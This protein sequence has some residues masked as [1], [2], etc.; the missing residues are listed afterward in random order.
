MKRANTGGLVL[1]SVVTNSVCKEG[2]ICDA[3]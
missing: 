1:N 2:N 3:Q